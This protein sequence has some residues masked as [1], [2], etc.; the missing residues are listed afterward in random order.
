MTMIAN[1]EEKFINGQLLL[2]SKPLGWSSF[3]V[4]KK[5]KNTIC[6]KYNLPI[7]AVGM[8]EKES[9]LHPFNAEY[10]VKALLGVNS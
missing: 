2:I 3:D 6:K 4:V 1:L 9:D 7:V 10:F 5:I 8:G